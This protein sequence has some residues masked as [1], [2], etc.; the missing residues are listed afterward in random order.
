MSLIYSAGFS[1]RIASRKVVKLNDVKTIL[2]IPFDEDDR[3]GYMKALGFDSIQL[4]G[5]Y[6]D[7]RTSRYWMSLR[8]IS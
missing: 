6:G 7:L 2:G 5:L 4:Y 3:L 8:R 1:P